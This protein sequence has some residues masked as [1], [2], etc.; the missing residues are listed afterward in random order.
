MNLDLEPGRLEVARQRDLEV[1]DQLDAA[2]LHLELNGEMPDE[3]PYAKAYTNKSSST[4]KLK[5][6]P[7]VETKMKTKKR[8]RTGRGTLPVEDASDAVAA[9]IVAAARARAVSTPVV[10]SDSLTST[11]SPLAWFERTNIGDRNVLMPGPPSAP[12]FELTSLYAAT[13]PEQKFTALVHSNGPDGPLVVYPPGAPPGALV[14][15]PTRWVSTNARK[16]PIRNKATLLD[17]VAWELRLLK[18]PNPNTAPRQLKPQ[19]VINGFYEMPALLFVPGSIHR[20]KFLKHGFDA[21]VMSHDVRAGRMLPP[22]VNMIAQATGAAPLLL[23]AASEAEPRP[24]SVGGGGH[25]GRR[26]APRDLS[27]FC[28][29]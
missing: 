20:E 8:Q 25:A 2:D 26:R 6:K 9:Q 11:R 16:S 14:Q 1:G 24:V 10:R 17:F 19:E 3:D 7:R 5:K 28:L 13:L 12:D 27:L 29:G 4:R 22:T 23:E 21:V 18:H 15:K